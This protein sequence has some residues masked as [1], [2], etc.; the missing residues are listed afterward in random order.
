MSFILGKLRLALIRN[1]VEFW[2]SA[3]ATSTV[4]GRHDVR[5]YLG[6]RLIAKIYGVRCRRSSCKKGG[7]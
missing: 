5:C 7:V 3:V 4:K 1:E 6:T 2:G